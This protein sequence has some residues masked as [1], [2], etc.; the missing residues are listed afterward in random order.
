MIDRELAM[1]NFQSV[2]LAN[3]SFSPPVVT[4]KDTFATKKKDFVS[5]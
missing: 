3:I 4:N 2:S 1:D 5:N